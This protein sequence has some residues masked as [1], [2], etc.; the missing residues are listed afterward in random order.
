MRTLLLSGGALIVLALLFSSFPRPVSVALINAPAPDIL[1]PLLDGRSFSPRDHPG[2]VV[3]LDFWATW[4]M[5]CRVTMP[6]ADRVAE[7]YAARDVHLYFV[8]QG[9][10][11]EVVSEF[12]EPTG[13]TSPVA[14]DTNRVLGAAFEVHA[15][16]CTV[17]I[18]RD[19]NVKSLR[20]GASMDY[21]TELRAD[22]D[23][24]L[25]E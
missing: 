19:G 10:P 6:I 3:V 4:C 22:L 24:V 15:L 5:P 8:N 17:I 2:D 20:F 16:P 11:R 23:R 9:E 18:G 21:E 12:I 14:L 25:A 13:L 7:E 1:L